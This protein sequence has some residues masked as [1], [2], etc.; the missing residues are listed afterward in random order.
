[1]ISYYEKPGIQAI[2][3]TSLDLKPGKWNGVL[4]RNYEY[5]RLS[6]VSLFAT[7]DLLTGEAVP[8]MRNIHNSD[9]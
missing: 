8:L 1:M 9:D 5:E 4:E 6:S 2:T 7:S 3:V